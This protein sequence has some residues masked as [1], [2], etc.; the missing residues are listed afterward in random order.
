M[1]LYNR[2]TWGNPDGG[3]LGHSATLVMESKK[4]YG[5]RS[6]ADYNAMDFVYG[7]LDGKKIKQVSCGFLHTTCLTEDG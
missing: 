7:E 3:K 1:I 4:G 6:Y 2:V 5:P